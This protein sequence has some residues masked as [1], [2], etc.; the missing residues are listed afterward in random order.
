M[1]LP[2]LPSDVLSLLARKDPDPVL[3]IRAA[4][5]LG[6]NCSDG[7]LNPWH[8]DAS[9][10]ST[11]D[12]H[13]VVAGDDSNGRLFAAWELG[14]RGEVLDLREL[15]VRRCVLLLNREGEDA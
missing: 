14:R 3:R 15:L 13:A 11:D 1:R 8:E 12:L 4:H 2:D 5:S 6:N 7:I 9:A 10:Y